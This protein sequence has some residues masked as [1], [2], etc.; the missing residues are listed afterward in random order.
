MVSA[1]DAE[2]DQTCISSLNNLLMHVSADTFK[3]IDRQRT[4]SGRSRK[5][6]PNNATHGRAR[7]RCALARLF[8]SRNSTQRRFHVFRSIDVDDLE[9]YVKTVRPQYTLTA[10]QVQSMHACEAA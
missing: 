5:A 3:R 7:M 9:L 4:Q 1:I 2:S 10:Q 8:I 6:L